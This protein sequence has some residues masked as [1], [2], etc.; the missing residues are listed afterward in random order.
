MAAKKRQRAETFARARAHRMRRATSTT[1]PL[2]SLRARGRARASGAAR[3]RAAAPP[4]AGYRRARATRKNARPRCV[5]QYD[6]CSAARGDG[7]RPSASRARW[8]RH[9]DRT[10]STRRSLAHWC[11]CEIVSRVQ[12]LILPAR[13]HFVLLYSLRAQTTHVIVKAGRGGPE[14]GETRYRT[15]AVTKAKGSPW[16]RYA[17]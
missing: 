5:H 12:S 11:S 13:A 1:I 10:P 14:H 6:L 4:A 17:S 7:A 16:K 3:R 9:G 8:T 2:Q 15:P